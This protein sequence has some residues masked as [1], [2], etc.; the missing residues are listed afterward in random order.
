MRPNPFLLAPLCLG[1]A[2]AILLL[3]RSTPAPGVSVARPTAPRIAVAAPIHRPSY[4][5]DPSRITEGME[6][7]AGTRLRG[8]LAPVGRGVAT[9]AAR[10]ARATT[11]ARATMARPAL[12]RDAARLSRWADGRAGVA[13]T[14][15]VAAA[16]AAGARANTARAALARLDA[17]LQEGQ[18]RGRALLRSSLQ[19][20]GTR[21]QAGIRGGI[22]ADARAVA[23]AMRTAPWSR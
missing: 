2:V 10:A 22:Q 11:A 15:I 14:G 1:L 23:R 5:A 16:G 19:Q 20:A 12:Q 4:A 17:R 6:R 21:I 13:R 18:H 3:T 7:D 8:L 9:T